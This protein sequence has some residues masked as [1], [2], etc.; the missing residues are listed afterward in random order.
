MKKS[1]MVRNAT[2]RSLWRDVFCERLG[3]LE[4]VESVMMLV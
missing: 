3:L 2:W 1:M 4:V